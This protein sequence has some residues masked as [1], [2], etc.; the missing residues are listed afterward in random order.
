MPLL[1]V[2]LLPF[3]GVFQLSVFVTQGAIPLR[4][5]L[6][7]ADGKLPLQGAKYEALPVQGK[8]ERAT[9]QRGNLLS[10]QGRA[11]RHPG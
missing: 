5:I 4:S 6:P 8:E 3:Q 1:V 9:P 2:L 11:K 7:W 10:A